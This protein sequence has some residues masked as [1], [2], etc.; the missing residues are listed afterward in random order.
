MAPSPTTTACRRGFSTGSTSPLVA[1]YFAAAGPPGSGASVYA[2]DWGPAGANHGLIDTSTEANG[3]FEFAAQLGRFAPAVFSRRIAEQEGAFTI[4]ANPL[5]GIHNVAGPKLHRHDV[6]PE[7]R[8][9]FLVDLF[10][11]GISASSLF[12][13]LPGLAETLRWVM[14]VICRP[15]PGLSGPLIPSP[16]RWPVRNNQGPNPVLHNPAALELL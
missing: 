12:R 16:R 14:N 7:D 3:P 6:K 11:F 15:A 5:F 9:E 8:A 13:D 10:R 1:L 4:Q 2:P